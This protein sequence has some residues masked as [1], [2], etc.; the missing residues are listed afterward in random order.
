MAHP[1]AQRFNMIANTVHPML[2]TNQSS[3]IFRDE[4][5]YKEQI[6]F[7]IGI[8]LWPDIYIATGYRGITG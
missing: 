1:F 2:K 7:C 6:I 5:L 8:D 4:Q 3:I